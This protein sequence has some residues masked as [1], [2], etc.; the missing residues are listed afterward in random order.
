[1][2]PAVIVTGG[3]GYIG[4]H[5]CKAL[6]EAGY[7]PV[8]YDDL[9]LGQARFVKWGPLIEGD[10]RDA[11]RVAS[12]IAAHDAVAVMHFAALSSVAESVAHPDR[13]F[14]VNLGGLIGVTEG[15]RR[16]GCKAIVFSSTAAV[17]GEP[18][19]SPI[20]EGA[21]TRPINPYGWSKRMGELLLADLGRS[22]GLGSVSLRYFNAAGA[23]P[24]GGIGE[25]RLAE[26]HLIPRALMALQGHVPDFRVFGSD[27]PTA[28]GTAVRDYVHVADL[29]RAHVLA[30][31]RVLERGGT[32][33]FNVG[34]G[35]GLSVAQVLSA[36]RRETGRDLGSAVG[37]RRPG[38]PAELVA[39][40]SRARTELGFE[41]RLS[42]IDTIV[43]TAW[44]W[45]QIAH[46]K[47]AG[48]AS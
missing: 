10:V 2:K 46:P 41:P 30:L 29:A 43:R 6:A 18:D 21:A 7:L 44:R 28:D 33:A 45:H 20:P 34:A 17:Y 9:S 5:S 8:A 22:E 38:D 39:D 47:R 40:G 12:T 3:A 1:M 32:E 27:F 24:D 14:D 11:A 13:Y 19:A 35:S 37:P 31:T 4:S 48:A 15:M 42:D 16:A 25:F 23:D 26:T 36:I